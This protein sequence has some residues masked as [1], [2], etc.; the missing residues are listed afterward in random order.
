MGVLPLTAV[1][2]IANEI[3][4]VK[5]LKYIWTQD[6]VGHT[7]EDRKVT[8]EQGKNNSVNNDVDASTANAS[9]AALASKQA[10]AVAAATATRSYASAVTN[11]PNDLDSFIKQKINENIEE[12]NRK[13]NIVITGMDEDYN[14]D[15]LIKEMFRVMGCGFRYHDICAKPTRLGPKNINKKR[16]IKVEMRSEESVEEIMSCKNKLKNKNGNFYAV[17][18]NRDLRREEKRK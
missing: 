17:Y 12:I 7:L 18:V 9:A 13:K 15:Y 16:A 4:D 14:D 1:Q 2:N 6:I 3:R 10:A 5:D 11:I 8:P